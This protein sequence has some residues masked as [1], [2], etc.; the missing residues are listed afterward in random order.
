MHP[1]SVGPRGQQDPGQRG[2]HRAGH[3][4]RGDS[5]SHRVPSSHRSHFLSGREGPILQRKKLR[6]RGGCRRG[7]AGP[8]A[9]LATFGCSQKMEG[10]LEEGTLAVQ[11]CLARVGAKAVHRRPTGERD[12]A[13]RRLFVDGQMSVLHDNKRLEDAKMQ[14]VNTHGFAKQF[15]PTSQ[16][17][18]GLDLPLS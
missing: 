10:F 2:L 6:L 7:L 9:E 5:W 4:E 11:L 17:G 3:K 15:S 14:S 13:R 12:G 16:A 8:E 18:G 1:S